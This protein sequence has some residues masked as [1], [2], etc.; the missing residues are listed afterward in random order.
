MFMLG[1]INGSK[2]TDTSI[3]GSSV[4]TN[5]ISNSVI[6]LFGLYSFS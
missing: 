3:T 1:F 5:A 4:C 2:G 6:G